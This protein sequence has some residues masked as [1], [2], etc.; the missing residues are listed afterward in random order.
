MIVKVL[1]KLEWRI[2]RTSERREISFKAEVRPVDEGV[3]VFVDARIP[4]LAREV[5][6]WQ[7]SSVVGWQ[8]VSR[9]EF[10]EL[11]HVAFVEEHLQESRNAN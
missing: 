4:V 10:V 6:G 2:F 8:V 5:N 7:I 11:L 3:M 1:R 9:N